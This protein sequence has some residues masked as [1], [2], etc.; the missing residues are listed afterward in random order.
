MNYS[1]PFLIKA[2]YD[3][4][5]LSSGTKPTDVK[6]GSTFLE[7]DT[8]DVYIFYEGT[9]YNQSS[10][11]SGDDEEALTPVTENEEE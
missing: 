4:V 9:W 3:L 8:S 7:V 2:K 5:G 11:S 1:N 10:S 6:N